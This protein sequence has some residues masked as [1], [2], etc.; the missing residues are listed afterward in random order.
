MI[1]RIFPW[2]RVALAGLLFAGAALPQTPNVLAGRVLD[3][4]GAL[5]P[6]ARVLLTG[7][8]GFSRTATSAADGAFSFPA[9][10]SG[11]YSLAASAPGLAT[12][13]PVPVRLAG[14]SLQVDLHVKILASSTQITVKDEVNTVSV[15]AENNASGTTISG[16]DLQSLSDDPDDLASD[17]Q[18]LAGPSAGLGGGAIF[19]DGFSDAQI[20]PKESIREIRINQNPFSPEYDK[21]GLGRVEIFTKPGT[22]KYHATVTYNYGTEHWNSRNP[23]AAQKAPFLL[24][25]TEN[26][27]SGPLG[28]RASFTLDLE[29]QWVDNGAVVNAVTLD[30]ALNAV[31][32][33]GVHLTPQRNLR[34]APHIDYQINDTTYL[35][36]RYLVGIA[37]ITGAG[38]DDFELVSRGYNYDNR[39]GN[40]QATLTS[41]HGNSVNETRFQYAKFGYED[42]P[43]LLTPEISVLGAFNG[44]G[45]TVGYQRDVTQSY[46]ASNY[47]SIQHGSHAWR[48]GVR[49]RRI[50]D[51]NYSRSN[52]NGTYTFT[53]I[54]QYRAT[55]LGLPGAGPA[56]F[57]LNAGN[58]SLSLRRFD[59][60]VFAGDD[61]RLRRNLTLSLGLR[62]EAQT[63]ISDFHDFAPRLG[64]AWA[65]GA[66]GNRKAK[67]VLRG[68]FGM[69]Y[70][71]LNL[72]NVLPAERYNGATQQQYVVSAPA[73]FPAVPPPAALAP[74]TQQSIRQIDARFRAPYVLQSALTVERQ[75]PKN[76][77][78][79]VT[80]TNSH[81][82]HVLRSIDINPPAAGTWNAASPA[83]AVYPLPG[84]GPVFLT[85]SSGLYNQNQLIVNVNAKVSPALSLFGYYVLNHA[86]SNSDGINTFPGNP[87]NFSGDYGRA[88][89]DVRH[90]LVFGGT[91][92][93]RGNVRLNPLLTAQSG[94]P[95]DITAGND[96]FGTTLFNARP[97]IAP[98]GSTKPGLIPTAYGLLDPNPSPGE[99]ILPRNAGNGPMQIQANLRIT[100]TWGFGG[101]R[102]AKSAAAGDSSVSAG[103]ALSAPQSTR[104]LFASPPA[105]S[106]YNLTVGLSLRN[107]LNHTNAGP[108]IGNITSPLFGLANQMAGT[109][110][111]QGFSENANNRRLELQLRFAF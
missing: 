63:I 29:R 60:G 81:A 42:I 100:R 66:V 37:R 50:T 11:A 51:D 30:S 27:G 65:P 67:T 80:Y 2:L 111:G 41:I 17:L 62:Y 74:S 53:S 36:V 52:F 18:A 69:F 91:I 1:S 56:Q 108:I 96:V 79:A 45:A 3:D 87:Y 106:R 68:G 75:L 73:F 10:P 44:G 105:P 59:A 83:A 90:R 89:T 104:G 4:A 72:S 24:N 70:D 109:I 77:T 49:F 95:F 5:V 13:Q 7:D 103:P 76:T 78:L 19:V 38:I 94:A 46:E 99:T 16:D 55:M 14:A 107:A 48:F 98:A 86:R 64:V 20:P 71:R 35:S 21:L 34:I 28:K 57:T 8:A 58:P 25:E 54:D 39:I 97:G 33:T 6:N 85:T 22:D 82:L 40:G 61:W 110:N 15:A 93:L 26:S 9:V 31:A 84:R 101:E 12:V 88:A 23:Y 92:A 102:G 43:S 32:F 47:T